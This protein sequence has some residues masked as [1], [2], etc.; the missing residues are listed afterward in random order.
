[1]VPVRDLAL[2][3]RMVPAN[4]YHSNAM[5]IEVSEDLIPALEKEGGD[6][7]IQAKFVPEKVVVDGYLNRGYGN[8]YNFD[9][10]DPVEGIF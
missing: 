7:K 2:S 8:A 6:L 1:M 5:K 10:Q 9:Q 4:L 3:G